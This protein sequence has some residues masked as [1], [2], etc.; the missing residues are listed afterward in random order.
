MEVQVKQIMKKVLEQH[1]KHK[2]LIRAVF[3]EL[4]YSDEYLV[5]AYQHHGYNLPSKLYMGDWGYIEHFYC[6]Y[7]KD[8]VNLTSDFFVFHN[9]LEKTTVEYV[10]Q[11]F[12]P[13]DYKDIFQYSIVYEA[14]FSK[15]DSVNHGYIAQELVKRLV[16]YNIAKWYVEAKQ[17]ELNHDASVN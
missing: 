8:I 13:D 17:T 14:L 5:H 12:I 10:I 3:K 4:Q 1:P 9:M 11:N 6:K 7:K 15:F 16:L 2:K